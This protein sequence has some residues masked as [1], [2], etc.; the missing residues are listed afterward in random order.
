MAESSPDPKLDPQKDGKADPKKDGKKDGKK[1]AKKSSSGPDF[2][3]IGGF[4]LALGGIAG[5]LLMEGGKVQDIAQV[6]SALIVLGGTIG[7]VMITTPLPVLIRAAKRLPSVVFPSTAVI[8]T[9]IEEIIEYATAARKNGIVSLEQQAAAIKDPFL[10]KALGLAVDGIETGNIREIMELEITLAEQHADQEAKVFEAAGGYA[11]TIGIIG[12]VLGLI[13]VMKNLANI[14]EVGRGIAVAFVAT[15]Y[16]VAIANLV[17]LPFAN[18]LKA[19]AHASTQIRELMLEGVL[20]IAEGLN[21]KL[22]RMK[23]E[24]YSEKHGKPEKAKD[25][26]KKKAPAAAKTPDAPPNAAPAEG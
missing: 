26:G 3:T 17:F 10:Q 6:T 22:I 20:S 12:A 19:R 9:V 21:Q 18:K 11:P 24:A 7:A 13:Q 5:G 8:D 23:L 16:G 14:D 25:K 2:A 4:V 15:I 1:A